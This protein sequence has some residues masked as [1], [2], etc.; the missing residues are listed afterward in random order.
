MNK[1]IIK[2]DIKPSIDE[3]INLYEDVKWIAYTNDVKQLKDAIDNSLKVWTA[4]DVDRL[5]GLARVIGDDYT[6]IY[7]Q[8]ILILEDYQNQGIGSKLLKL[9][10]E[11]YKSI[12]QIVLMTENT[13]K[14]IRF[15]QKN[16]MVKT[17]E[18]NC[19]TFM[20]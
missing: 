13:E 18:Y 3:L 9:I 16:G 10:L 4:W 19:I 15:Y 12:R 14:T 1:I 6:I 8:D 11:Q 2:D 20:K 5:V 7:I 17:S